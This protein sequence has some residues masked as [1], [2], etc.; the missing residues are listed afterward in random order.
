VVRI[1][2]DAGHGIGSTRD[3]VYGELADAYAFILAA[4][5]DP[6]FQPR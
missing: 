3:Q 5:G 6:A 1:D 4:A 2:A